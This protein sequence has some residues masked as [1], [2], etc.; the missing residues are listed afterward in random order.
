MFRTELAAGSDAKIMDDQISIVTP[1]H[2]ELEFSLAGLGSRMLALIIDALLVGVILIGVILAAAILGF[3]SILATQRLGAGSW[4]V[5]VAV[6]ALFIVMWGYF[7]LFEALNNGQTPGKRWTGIRV[8][9]D[10]GLPLGW[11]ESA[12]RNLVRAADIL[13]PPACI[14]GG[15]SIIFSKT[16]KRLGDLLAGT[17]VVSHGPPLEPAQ[18]TSRWGAAWI[19]KVEKG[20]SRQGMMV[21]DMRVDAQQLQIIERFLARRDALPPSQRQS[22]AW[23]IAQ[24]F[25]SALGEDA[26]ELQRRPDRF[27]VCEQALQKI[28]A[29]ADAT[30]SALTEMVSEDDADAKRRRWREFNQKISRF[31]R[32]RGGDLR[33]LN[34]DQLTEI[35]DGYRTLACDL[36]RARSM[37]KNSAVVR[38]LNGIAVRA[39]SVL[40]RRILTTDRRRGPAWVSRF[41]MAVRSHL[42][43][44]GL[45]ALLLFG[46]AVISYLAVQ[47]RPEFAY[48][49]VPQSFLDFEPARPESLHNIPGFARPI[50]ASSIL[51]NNIQVTLLAFGFG[52]TA[53]IGTAFVLI[54][55]GIQLGAVAGW[56]TAKGNS[57]ALWGWIMPHGGTELLAIVL[58]GAAG[59]MLARAIIAPGEIRRPTALRRV[60]IPALTIELGVMVMLIFAGLIEGFVSPSSIGFPARIAVLSASLIFW[61][62]YLA[63]A[64]L[65]SEL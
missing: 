60:A 52:L 19:V 35:M 30:P 63:L 18:R 34:P 31:E 3:G 21:G 49:L 26:A 1:D 22:L 28:M 55:N 48:D 39:H 65:R 36:A 11:K 64:G 51:T 12:L 43:A 16:G 29:L 23:R 14:V 6:L 20:R 33:R 45:S 44:V 24:P 50:A 41:P 32:A 13:P 46:P 10:N 37:G 17:I 38:H 4:V 2:I 56:M 40:Y 47:I 62:G 59:F 42:A 61:F 9:R 25:L 53:G 5:A 27:Q 54:T 7:L 58:A 57:S 8:V 15:L